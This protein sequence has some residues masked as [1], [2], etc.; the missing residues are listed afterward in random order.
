[1]IDV[2][3]AGALAR[4]ALTN[5]AHRVSVQARSGA[6]KRGR[7]ARAALAASGFLRQLRLALVRAHALEPGP[8]AAAYPQQP[9]AAAIRDHFDRR[10]T[11]DAIAGELHTLAGPHRASF[12]RPY[13]WGWLLKLAAELN[14]S[15]PSD[16]GPFAGVTHSRRWR[17]HSLIASSTFCRAQLIRRAPEPTATRRSHCCSRSIIARPLQHRA[18]HRAD[19]RT[20]QPVVRS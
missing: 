6:G 7:R 1:M 14:S 9:E 19:H 18:L 12:E 11:T 4:V 15:P 5:V 13:G 17:R 10:V 20:C 2:E 8:R 3:F 16:P